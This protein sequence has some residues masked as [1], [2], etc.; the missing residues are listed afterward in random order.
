[1][2]CHHLHQLFSA[3]SYIDAMPG[4]FKM[5]YKPESCSIQAHKGD[6]VKVH[7]RV[8]LLL[9]LLICPL[10]LPNVSLLTDVLH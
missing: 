4:Y 10:M 1:M 7:Y 3:G 9:C 5:Q 8:S 2:C 6:K